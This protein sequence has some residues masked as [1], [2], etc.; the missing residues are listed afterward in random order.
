VELTKCADEAMYRAKEAGR[1]CVRLCD[2][3]ESASPQ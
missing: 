3:A 1:D 2:L